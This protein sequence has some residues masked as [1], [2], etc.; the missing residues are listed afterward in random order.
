MKP[1][2]RKCG[3][4]EI[5][6]ATLNYKKKRFLFNQASEDEEVCPVLNLSLGGVNF[7]SHKILEKGGELTLRL[8]FPGKETA[9]LIIKGKVNHSSL[10][11]GKSYKYMHGITF[12]PYG[13]RKGNN[14]N[15]ILE[16]LKSLEAI[17]KA[18]TI[19]EE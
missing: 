8:F 5:P 14:E 10:S 19:Q 13:E 2:K 15:S 9:P 11:T 12:H 18:K 6:G 17:Y 1:E 7:L 3:R 4:F 16:K